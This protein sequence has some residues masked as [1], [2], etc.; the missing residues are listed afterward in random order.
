MTNPIDE[1]LVGKPREVW[2]AQFLKPGDSVTGTIVSSELQQQKEFADDEKKGVKRGDPKFW[3]DGKP[4]NQLRIVLQTTDRDV[5]Y[6]NDTGKRAV[7][8]KGELANAIRDAIKTSGATGLTEGAELGVTFTGKAGQKKL[9]S[10]TYS[11]AKSN[12][13]ASVAALLK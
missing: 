3:D 7:Y 6:D 2:S 1:F 8:A 5:S 13:P 10:A 11:S 12:V 4:M 9:Y